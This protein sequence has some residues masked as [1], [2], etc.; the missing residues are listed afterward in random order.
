MLS[1]AVSIYSLCGEQRTRHRCDLSVYHSDLIRQRR[2][3]P[4]LSI[5]RSMKPAQSASLSFQ[6]S[7]LQANGRAPGGGVPLLRWLK[8]TIDAKTLS[9]RWWAFV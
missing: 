3:K 5:C 2:I 1:A 6:K 8:E 7:K 9:C 4:T